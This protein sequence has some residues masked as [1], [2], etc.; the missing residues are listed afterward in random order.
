MYKLGGWAVALA[1][2]A[3]SGAVMLNSKQVFAKDSADA[4]QPLFNKVP[5]R[6][7]SIA[8]LKQFDRERP[9]DVLVL[10]GGATGAGC[11]LDAATR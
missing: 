5:S 2:G 6:R 10:G 4:S 11:A 1:V 8:K 7:H 9:F 3:G